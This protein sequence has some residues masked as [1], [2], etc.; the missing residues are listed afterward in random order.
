MATLNRARLVTL[1]ILL[2]HV[3]TFLLDFTASA[4]DEPPAMTLTA[5]KSMVFAMAIE[6]DR[7]PERNP[8]PS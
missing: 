7:P 1:L 8:M 5:I 2:D 6:K 4:V 3:P